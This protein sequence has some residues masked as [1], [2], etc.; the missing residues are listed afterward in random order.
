MQFSQI[1]TSDS[2]LKCPDVREAGTADKTLHDVM[3][4]LVHEEGWSLDDALHEMS[5]VRSDI[6]TLLQPRPR[7]L[8][9]LEGSG[10][11]KGNNFSRSY[12]GV[13]KGS[14]KGNWDPVKGPA[15]ALTHKGVWSIGMG[16]SGC[17]AMDQGGKGIKG[18]MV[19]GRKGRKGNPSL[20]LGVGYTDEYQP[21]TTNFASALAPI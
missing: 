13:G 1:Y 6:A 5:E 10:K 8:Q 15:R 12:W 14:Y 9:T 7:P 17:G 19:N 11:G 21:S 20:E 3:Y 4:R 18:G 2:G 16:A